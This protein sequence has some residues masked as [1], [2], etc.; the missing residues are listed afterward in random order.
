MHRHG[1]PEAEVLNFIHAQQAITSLRH[2]MPGK[3]KNDTA[4]VSSP[5]M[6]LS[7]NYRRRK[8]AAGRLCSGARGAFSYT[9][10]AYHRR[11][12]AAQQITAGNAARRGSGVLVDSLRYLAVTREG[13]YALMSRREVF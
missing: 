3:A 7:R 4:R 11:A 5:G 12:R 1:V 2:F 6:L 13:D 9:V 10:G 8:R